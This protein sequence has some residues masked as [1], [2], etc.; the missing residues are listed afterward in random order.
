MKVKLAQ[1][2]DEE[3]K[4]ALDPVQE[5][6]KNAQEIINAITQK[7][8]IMKMLNACFDSKALSD[9]HKVTHMCMYVYG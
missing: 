6:L 8:F 4:K 1:R 5:T 7:G 9:L 2:S 3:Q